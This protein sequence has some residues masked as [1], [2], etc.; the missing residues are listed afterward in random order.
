MRHSREIWGIGASIRSRDPKAAPEIE[1]ECVI[2]GA[3]LRVDNQEFPMSVRVVFRRGGLIGIR[4]QR[5]TEG[6]ANFKRLIHKLSL[7][8]FGI[9]GIKGRW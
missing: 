6:Q 9:S 1:S 4:F 8:A 3:V 7:K 5:I 2:D